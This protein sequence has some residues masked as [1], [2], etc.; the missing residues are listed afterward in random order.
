MEDYL[1]DVVICQEFAR[2]NRE[3]MAKIIIERIGLEV[4]ETFHTI[5]NYIDTKEMI[6]R[7]RCDCSSQWGESFNSDKYER[8]KCS[9]HRKRKS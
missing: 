9:C 1:H 8:R 7:E 3:L 4:E 6:L 2:R 5:H